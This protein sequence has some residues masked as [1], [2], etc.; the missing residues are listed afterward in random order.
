MRG[1]I[2]RASQAAPRHHRFVSGG[3]LGD[4]EAKCFSHHARVN[5]DIA[6]M[7][8]VEFFIFRFNPWTISNPFVLVEFLC[9]KEDKMKILPNGD[10][11]SYGFMYKSIINRLLAC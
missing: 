10:G 1:V 9:G 3:K 8:N 6:G 7:N 11:V 5:H 2:T 4:G